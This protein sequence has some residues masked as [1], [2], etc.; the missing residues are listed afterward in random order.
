[1]LVKTLSPTIPIWPSGNV[2]LAIASCVEQGKRSFNC[3]VALQ[4]KTIYDQILHV[5]FNLLMDHLPSGHCAITDLQDQPPYTFP[6]HYYRASTDAL[7]ARTDLRSDI[8]VWNDATRYVM[9]LELTVCDKTNFVD[10]YI[11]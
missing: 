9:M 10:A 1:M 8:V 4:L 11:K 7:I 2:S 3:P 6:P 5:I